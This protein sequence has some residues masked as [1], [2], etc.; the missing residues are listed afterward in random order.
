MQNRPDPRSRTGAAL[1]ATRLLL[2]CEGL[3][4]AQADHVLEHGR[5]WRQVVGVQELRVEEIVSRRCPVD[6]VAALEYAGSVLRIVHA[7]QRSYI[8][9]RGSITIVAAVFKVAEEIVHS[10]V[11]AE[12]FHAGRH[13]PAWIGEGNALTRSDRHPVIT[14]VSLAPRKGGRAGDFYSLTG[15]LEALVVRP[16]GVCARSG[17]A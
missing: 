10:S 11:G 4:I 1:A 16:A 14:G 6:R 3:V 5:A 12:I 7:D 13:R 8:I 9:N 15:I 17:S 2:R